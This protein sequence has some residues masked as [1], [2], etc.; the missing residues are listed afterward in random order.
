M[1][2]KT[3]ARPGAGRAVEL[4]PVARD[5]GFDRYEAMPGSDWAAPRTAARGSPMRMR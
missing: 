3:A 5:L 4:S 1:R 2:P